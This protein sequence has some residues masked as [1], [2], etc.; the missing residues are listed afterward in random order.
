MAPDGSDIRRITDLGLVYGRPSW[1]SDGSK[2]AFGA[3]VNG[4]YEVF[5]ADAD[6]GGLVQLTD[7]PGIDWEPWLSPDGSQVLLRER[8]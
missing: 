5:I 2:L 6:G 7:Q 4:S 1:S 8:S 3:M